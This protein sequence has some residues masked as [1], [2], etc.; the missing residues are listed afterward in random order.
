[1]REK[2]KRIFVNILGGQCLE[3]IAEPK[4][5]GETERER[6]ESSLREIGCDS[7]SASRLS[8]EIRGVFLLSDSLSSLFSVAFLLSPEATFSSVR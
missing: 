4:R 6:V 2:L 7:M 1:M 8:S 3:V 5:E